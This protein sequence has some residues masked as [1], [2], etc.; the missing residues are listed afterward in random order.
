MEQKYFERF[1]Q[2][3][4]EGTSPFHVI[5]ASVRQLEAAGF[6]P[7]EFRRAWKI[8][9]GGKY[10]VVHHGSTLFA[11]T[12]GKRMTHRSALRMAASHGDFPALRIKT[13]PEI[14][15]EG[16]QKLNVEVYGGAI[17]NT[18]LDRPLSVAGRVALKG[19]DSFHPRICYVDLQKPIL[20][21]PNMA[22]HINREVN[23]GVELNRQIDML[24]ICGMDLSDRE[25]NED[26]EAEGKDAAVKAKKNK[27]ERTEFFMEYLSKE[28]QVKK[29]EIL[30]F[31]LNVYNID[32]PM[33]VGLNEQF[34][35][36]PRL[37]N[38]T[39][40]FAILEALTTGERE[41][42]IN[43]I[44]IFDH[45]EIGS[46]TKQG[47]GSV[48]L[49]WVLE[50]IYDSLGISRSVYMENVS[51]GLLLS[52]DVSHGLHPNHVAKYDVTNKP[53][54]GGGICIKEAC[55]QSYATDCE[56]V[57]IIQQLCEQEG[58]ACQKSVNRSDGTGG[59][60]LGAIAGSMLPVNI[61]DLGVP[62]LAMHSARELMG[63]KD[64]MAAQKLL[65]VFF[66]A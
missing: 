5:H 28:L 12:V 39:S 52:V 22:I 8:E 19:E 26:G 63:T 4:K 2:Y 29:E 6:A 45:E 15:E 25:K 23:K 10:Y 16:Y 51:D 34:L 48:L 61:V 1:F 33:F 46:R 47:A 35:S 44:A 36:A 65:N 53:V 58:I 42:G 57:A 30:D 7:L 59:S 31:E 49:S 50:K 9:S 60:T 3:I 62:L 21:V 41:D 40:S 37:D 38:L 54:L 24:P 43:L 20:T 14:K 18:W 11:F 13:N 32:E 64:Q 56:A 55:S 66:T 27:E 17:L